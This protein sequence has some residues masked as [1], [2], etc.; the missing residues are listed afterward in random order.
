MTT[1]IIVIGG[2][3]SGFMA[4]IT[5]AE[6]APSARIVILERSKTVLNKVRISGGGRCNVT[7][8]PY[9]SV[10]FAQ[11]YP[12]GEKL[13]KKTLRQFDAS[14]TMEWF[15][16]RGVALKTETDGRVFPV[17]DSSGSI[18]YCLSETARKLGIE[19]RTGTYVTKFLKD[20]S[21]G[22]FHLTLAGGEIIRC[23]K[24]LVATGGHPQI[25]GFDWLT[26]NGLTLVPPVPSLFTFNTPGNPLLPLAGVSVPDVVIRI[27]GSKLLVRGPLLI[28]HWGFSGPAA[29]KL[30]A[31][32]ARELADRNYAFDIRINWVAISHEDQVRDEL[33]K[34][35]NETP[36]Q[37]VGTHA[38]FGIPSRLWKALVERADIDPE[39]R[40]S[41]ASHKSL[42]R[43]ASHLTQSTFEVKGKT[44]YKEEF[45]TCGGI[46]LQDIN[47]DT[48]ECKT[49]KGL[50]LAGEVIDADGITGGFNFQNAW[51]SGYIAGKNMASTLS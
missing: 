47:A 28:T 33:Y 18:I 45:V 16:K 43:L 15:E 13:L 44:T 17:S 48:M 38:R 29:L 21:D 34:Q 3:A 4:A 10:P 27:S 8:T 25:S 46:S 20:T 41:D 40:W 2:G 22:L 32:G 23:E 1:N 37:Q 26:D 42:N 14:A 6:T 49:I 7:H 36:K 11:N 19:V 5:A 24:L 12:R 30:S 35:K 50:Y 39:S 9:P 51:T 31:W